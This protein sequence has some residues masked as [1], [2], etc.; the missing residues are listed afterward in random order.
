MCQNLLFLYEEHLYCVSK[1]CISFEISAQTVSLH[2][3]QKRCRGGKNKPPTTIK[4]QTHQKK[5]KQKRIFSIQCNS[6][7][8][9][10]LIMLWDLSMWNKEKG[11]FLLIYWLFDYFFS[12]QSGS[13]Q[14]CKTADEVK[15]VQK[16]GQF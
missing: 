6:I 5:T 7:W 15:T 14:S 4:N 3:P 1:L 2:R 11:L 10:K 12:P 9:L 16:P 8:N 13:R